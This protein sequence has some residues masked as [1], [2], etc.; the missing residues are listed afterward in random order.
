MK[1]IPVYLTRGKETDVT[2]RT[3]LIT[4]TVGKIQTT[5][6]EREKRVRERERERQTRHMYSSAKTP[7]NDKNG[8]YK[9]FMMQGLKFM[10]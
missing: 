2:T 4:K 7:K 5:A 1:N 8:I 9:H 6:A 10:I 3:Q